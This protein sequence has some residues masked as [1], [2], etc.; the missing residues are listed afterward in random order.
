MRVHKTG[1]LLLISIVFIAGM[2]AGYLLRGARRDIA[3]GTDR[4][5]EGGPEEA[6]R[7]A[8]SLEPAHRPGGGGSAREEERPGRGSHP[9]PGSPDDGNPSEGRTAGELM[10]LLGRSLASKDFRSFK[11][12]AEALGDLDA[13]QV[14]RLSEMLLSADDPRAAELLAHE[15]V[16]HGGKEGLLAVAGLARDDRAGLDLRARAI[17]AL[18]ELPVERREEGSTMLAGLLASGLPANLQHLAARTYGRLLGEGAVPGLLALI[19]GGGTRPEVLLKVLGSFATAGDVPKLTGLLARTPGA[20]CQ[21]G[22]LRAIGGA[23]GREGPRLLRELLADPP[24]GVRREAVARAL[25]QFAGKEDLSGLWESLGGEEDRQVQAALARAIARNGGPEEVEKLARLAADPASG[26]SRESIARALSDTASKETVPYLLELLGSARTWEAAEPLARG[27]AR[28]TGREGLEQVLA[29]AEQGGG[30]ERERA[31]IQVIEDFGDPGAVD[32]LSDLF[33]REKDQGVSFHLA[34]AIL[35]LDPA[36]G[37]EAI[38]GRLAEFPDPNQRSAIA[39]VLER[40]GNAAF[41]PAIG[42]VLRGERDERAQWQ[43]ARAIASYG[44]EGLAAVEE[45]LSTDPDPRRRA[46]VLG[47]ASSIRPDELAGI[48]RRLLR[49]DP[50]PEVRMRAAKALAMSGDPQAAELLQA[51]LGSEG[52]PKMREAIEASLR[53]LERR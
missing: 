39:Q 31:L 48:S 5:G 24:E 28:V 11:L 4:G 49:E 6:R 18:G 34:K 9:V 21:E 2:A 32:R 33:A 40:E 36:R 12:A 35:R 25:D 7:E 38:A 10:D 16:R 44:G 14:A 15:L 13:A 23:A 26:L 45:I 51:A 43:M 29:L 42:K 17:E 50:S 47:G 30:E 52:D 53:D 20:E 1:F 46:S 3:A 22:L 19:E 41:I 8:G 37:Q 27:I